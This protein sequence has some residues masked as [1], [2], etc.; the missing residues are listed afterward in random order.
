MN[1]DSTHTNIKNRNMKNIKILSVL[2]VLALVR[3]AYTQQDAHFTQYVDNLMLSNPAYA[4]SKGLISANVMH[5]E[6]W[7][8]IEGYPRTSTFFLHS[9]LRYESIGLGISLLNDLAGPIRQSVLM[10][11]ASYALRFNNNTKLSIGIKGGINIV[12]LDRDRLYNAGNIVS[13]IEGY[14]KRINPNIGVG[15]MYHGQN[16]FVGASMPKTVENSYDKTRTN[17]EKQHY[18]FHAGY[19]WTLNNTWK[20]RPSV[21]GKATR[22]AFG[23]DASLTAIYKDQLWLGVLYR[24]EVAIGGFIQVQIQ[25]QLK[26][27][28]GSDFGTQEIRHHNSGTLEALL[29]Y[30]FSLSKNT[31]NRAKKGVYSPRYF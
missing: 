22:G 24:M 30:D 17:M 31:A 3:F 15:V 11:D 25:P 1:I 21:Q 12:S 4:G 16:F 26:V 20:L 29:S 28:I 19:I 13:G 6:Q 7:T 10:A 14:D 23:A 2:L 18:Y 8:R 27:G 9:P 5:R